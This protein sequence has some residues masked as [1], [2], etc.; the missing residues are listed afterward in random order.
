MSSL[1]LPLREPLR[2]LAFLSLRNLVQQ[3]KSTMGHLGDLV[4]GQCSCLLIR[5]VT[6]IDPL[7]T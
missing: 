2:A 4:V 6:D 7:S 3:R 1:R 5:E